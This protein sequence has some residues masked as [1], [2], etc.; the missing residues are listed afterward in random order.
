MAVLPE[1]QRRGIG[2]ALVHD[3]RAALR[4]LGAEGCV[5]LGEPEFYRRFGF[6]SCPELVLDEVDPAYFLS[7]VIGQSPA[8]GRVSYH[9]AFDAK[10]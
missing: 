3:G 10:P 9:A 8:R 6:R 4:G 1:V 5:L 2:Q 7:L